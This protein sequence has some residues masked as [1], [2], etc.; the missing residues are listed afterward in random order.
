MKYILYSAIF[1]LITGLVISCGNLSSR[2]IVIYKAECLEDMASNHSLSRLPEAHYLEKFLDKYRVKNGDKY[3]ARALFKIVYE[4]G[5]PKSI[6]GYSDKTVLNF[7]GKDF[8]ALEFVYEKDSVLMKML[9]SDAPIL[10]K[11]KDLA[12]TPYIRYYLDEKGK[13]RNIFTYSTME[14]EN[15]I[16]RIDRTGEY[17]RTLSYNSP[18]GQPIICSNGFHKIIW[19]YDNKQ[20]PIEEKYFD[21]ADNP[22]IPRNRGYAIVRWNYDREGNIIQE[23]YFD[24]RGNPITPRNRGYATIKWS[25]HKNKKNH[26]SYFG[27]DGSPKKRKDQ[28]YS[29]IKMKYDDLGNIVEASYFDINGNPVMH[30]G[31]AIIKWKYDDKSNI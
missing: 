24:D 23:S 13:V 12:Y 11:F 6:K 7:L 31:Y 14:Q 19:A 10:F 3:P 15:A 21:I 2:K 16:I 17:S 30:N 28:D 9:Y 26:E 27:I 1:L 4:K 5:A 22:I 18:N 20:N 8:T 25:Y 29:I